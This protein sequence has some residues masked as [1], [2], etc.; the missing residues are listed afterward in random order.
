M[1]KNKK[2]VNCIDASNLPSLTQ[3]EADSLMEKLKAGDIEARERFTLGNLR[4]VLSVINHFTGKKQSADD[5]FQSGCVGLLKAI[6]NFDPS[7]GVR[8]STYAVP[9]NILW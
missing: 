7:L 5:M 1:Q 4:L 8:F 2:T 3:E 6:D 9:M